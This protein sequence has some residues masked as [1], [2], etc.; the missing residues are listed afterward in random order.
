MKK[1]LTLQALTLLG[2]MLEEKETEFSLSGTDQQ[3]ENLNEL[4]ELYQDLYRALH[5][6]SH[7][8]DC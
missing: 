8:T 6:R 1:E 4:W 2:D 3:I 7:L 5:H